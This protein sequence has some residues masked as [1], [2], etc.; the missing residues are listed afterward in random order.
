MIIISADLVKLTVVLVITKLKRLL[1]FYVKLVQYVK[2][3][4]VC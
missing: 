2:H 3:T 1:I 4:N